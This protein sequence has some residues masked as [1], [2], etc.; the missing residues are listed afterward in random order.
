MHEVLNSLKQYPTQNYVQK[1]IDFEKLP[2]IL[3]KSKPRSKK[4]EMHD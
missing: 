4:N 2:K 1:L 3:Q